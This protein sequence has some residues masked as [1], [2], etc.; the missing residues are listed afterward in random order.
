MLFFFGIKQATA[1]VEANKRRQQVPVRAD[2]VS[3]RGAHE[4]HGAGE[5]A[6]RVFHFHR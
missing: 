6:D 5:D 2:E 4:H 3:Q 1:E